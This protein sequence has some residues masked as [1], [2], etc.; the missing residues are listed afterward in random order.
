MGVGI[1]M[2]ALAALCIFGAVK[3]LSNNPSSARALGGIACALGALFFAAWA[4][5]LF[6][7]NLYF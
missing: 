3:L 4:F 2:T 6:T 1:V 7:P 5:N